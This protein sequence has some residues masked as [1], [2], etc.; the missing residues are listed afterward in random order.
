ML[1]HWSR[2]EITTVS[3]CVI[4]CS[5]CPQQVFQERYDGC[6]TLR[7]SDFKIALSK[8]PKSVAIHFSGF[9]EPFLNPQCIDMIEYAHR[10]GYRIFLFSTLVG[11][12]S[13]DLPRLQRCKPKLTLHLPDKLGNAKIPITQEYKETLK[14]TF[15]QISVDTFY[16]MNEHFISNERAGS[17]I[18][19]PIRHIDGWL[20]CEKLFVP[21]F[22]MLPNCDVALCCMDYGLKHTLGNLVSQFWRDILESSEYQKVCAN[23]FK[24]DGAVL[25][26]RCAW[27]SFAFRRSFYIKRITQRYYAKRF[28]QKY[29]KG[30]YL[31]V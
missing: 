3:N 17:C 19:A 11:L 28:L 26:R 27:A 25:C 24:M 18:N 12:K 21:Q 20:F 16:V 13:K 23:R 4:D 1:Q 7:L 14:A 5:F 8:V 6:K 30:V 31:S 9:A 22:V 29:L 2:L 10:E 15:E